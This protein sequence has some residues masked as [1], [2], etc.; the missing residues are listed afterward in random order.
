MVKTAPTKV[1]DGTVSFIVDATVMQSSVANK[2][3]LRI[4]YT[5]PAEGNQL[6]AEAEAAAK[7]EVAKIQKE[8]NDGTLDWKNLTTKAIQTRIDRATT[9]ST[10]VSDDYS[11]KSYNDYNKNDGLYFSPVGK[12]VDGFVKGTVVLYICDAEVYVPIDLTI[13]AK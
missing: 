3:S 12:G 5:L 7:A 10:L 1:K 9:S 11:S 8:L 4:T 13:P 6:I 2:A